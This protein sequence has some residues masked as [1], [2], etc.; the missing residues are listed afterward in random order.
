VNHDAVA[1]TAA[2]KAER[3]VAHSLVDQ[4][5][6]APILRA[7]GSPWLSPPRGETMSEQPPLVFEE[8]LLEQVERDDPIGDVAR[9]LVQG[10]DNPLGL[11]PLIAA[12][13]ETSERDH[14]LDGYRTA[15]REWEAERG[16]WHTSQASLMLERLVFELLT[17]FHAETNACRDGK[18]C[19]ECRA[20]VEG[21]FGWPSWEQWVATA[22][23]LPTG[24]ES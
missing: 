8:W 13:A 15:L 24:D 5:G 11:I 21:S 22:E 2:K 12:E 10:S 3:I 20:L 16:R 18:H 4:E 6:T 17:R 19:N 14:L 1:A 7:S 23:A 9:G